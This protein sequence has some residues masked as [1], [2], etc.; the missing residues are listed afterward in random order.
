MTNVTQDDAKAISVMFSL[1]RQS[2]VDITGDEGVRQWNA[3]LDLID[4][5]INT[6][7]LEAVYDSEVATHEGS[8]YV[9]LGLSEDFIQFIQEEAPNIINE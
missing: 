4:G 9:G 5:Y 1:I 7:G 6:H 8:Q 3:T 2:P